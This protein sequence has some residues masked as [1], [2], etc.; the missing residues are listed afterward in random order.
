MSPQTLSTIRS[1]EEAVAKLVEECRK[2][3][4]LYVKNP[5]AVAQVSRTSKWLL[6]AIARLHKELNTP[7]A[8][9]KPKAS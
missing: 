9:V 5:R 2:S 1:A 3:S 7:S 8:D 4:R 6:N